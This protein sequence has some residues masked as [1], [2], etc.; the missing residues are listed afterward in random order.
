MEPERDTGRL[1]FDPQRPLRSLRYVVHGARTWAGPGLYYL[2]FGK[3]PARSDR[4]RRWTFRRFGAEPVRAVQRVPQNA[5]LTL[6]AD[7]PRATLRG[8]AERVWDRHLPEQVIQRAEL[9]AL[10]ARFPGLRV[11][12]TSASPRVVVEVARD[13]LGAD[14]IESSELGRINSGRAKMARLFRRFPDMGDPEIETVGM[15]DTGYGEDHCWAE[16]LT[17]VVDV[18]SD[19]PFSPIVGARSP[20]RELHSAALITNRERA[21]RDAG[22]DGW[23]DPRRP[24]PPRDGRRVLSRPE[25]VERLGDLL[26]Q[27]ET[28]AEQPQSNAWR[29]ASLLREARERLE[30]E[31]RELPG[32]SAVVPAGA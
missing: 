17:R 30:E 11:I 3:I 27:L 22:E 13:R 12:I 8:L 29:I 18:N 16:H 19:T 10:R 20:L 31:P 25:L 1:L 23:M 5:L 26:A 15:T 2:L 28:L 14:A 32:A 7:V 24:R 9:D 21:A 4:M 6:L